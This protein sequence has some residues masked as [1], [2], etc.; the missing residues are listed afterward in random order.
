[1]KAYPQYKRNGVAY[2]RLPPI[3]SIRDA[4]VQGGGYWSGSFWIVPEPLA[5]QLGATIMVRVK[6]RPY[7][8]ETGPSEIWASK[9]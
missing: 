4:V 6:I 7:C 5:L 3:N 1:M 2:Y 8:H 9:R